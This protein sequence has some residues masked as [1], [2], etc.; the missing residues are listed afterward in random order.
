MISSNIPGKLLEKIKAAG[1]WQDGWQ[2]GSHGPDILA[3]AF[4]LRSG[5]KVELIVN[6]EGKILYLLNPVA[7]TR[8]EP[9]PPE[10][11]NFNFDPSDIMALCGRRVV[12][13]KFFPS[14]KRHQDFHLVQLD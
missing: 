5:R 3:T 4:R 6:R 7:Y 9:V 1:H 8:G 13:S 12:R 14:V 11:P 10:S 2:R